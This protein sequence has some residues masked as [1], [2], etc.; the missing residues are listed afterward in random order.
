[1]LERVINIKPISFIKSKEIRKLIILGALFRIII[2]AS[3]FNVT[4][5]PDSAGYDFLANYF[6]E[7]GLKNYDGTRTLG[8]PMLIILAFGKHTILIFYQFILGIIT[9]I[10]WYKTLLN[11]NFNRKQSFYIILF[12]GSFIHI[13]FFETAILIES[14]TLFFMSLVF[15]LISNGFLN[16]SNKKQDW[17]MVFLTGYLILL[18]PFF[19]FIPFI[20][21]GFYLLNNF[22]FGKIIDHKIIIIVNALF[23]YLGISYINKINTGH[24]VSTTFLGLNL[25]QNCVYFAENT[26]DEYKEF[27]KVYA[28]QREINTKENKDP[29]MAIWHGIN[30]LK[31]TSGIEY[32]PDYSAYLGDY[33]KETI[34]LNKE[35]YL[36]Q[37]V[38]ISWLDFWNTDIYWN[39][40]NFKIPYINKI[41]LLVWYI[42][43]TILII[44]KF[45][46]VLL[47]PLYIIRFIKNK[48]ITFEL[49]VA[50]IVFAAS[51]LQAI[52]TF[53][54]NS[55][56]SF[57]FEY[58]M[59]IIVL[60][61]MREQRLNFL[62]K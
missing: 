7:F 54:T 9:W 6:I 16:S 19:V 14:V 40:N 5:F 20:I 30:E 39:Y 8:Y 18:K 41:F 52:I 37:V 10:F 59:I 21:Y 49:V 53:G 60:M 25:S 11:L 50:T 31:A 1:M 38:T 17:I 46:F 36:K 13:F 22:N 12:L 51:V 24:F 2:F 42:Q 56:Y 32:F 48:K 45:G 27:G 44:F 23:I 57:P 47:V 34:S 15:Y 4:I 33:A 35:K 28:K 29:A 61:F 26:S 55:R 43:K 3:Y 62:N 58:L